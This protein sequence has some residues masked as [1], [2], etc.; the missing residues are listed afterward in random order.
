MTTY[1]MIIDAT[2]SSLTYFQADKYIY[3]SSRLGMLKDSVNV[4]G[5]AYVNTDMN[6][7]V[8][9]L[10]S[11]RYEFSN[12]LGNVLSVISDKPIP[13][14]NGGTVDYWMADIKNSQDYSPFGVML[15]GRSFG[16]TSYSYAFQAQ[17]KDD[18]IKGKGNSY[19][20][21]YRMHDTRLGRFF[22]VDPLSAKYPWNS[23]YAFSEN[24]VIDGVELEGLEWIRKITIRLGVYSESELRQATDKEIEMY[25]SQFGYEKDEKPDPDEYWR[26]VTYV[27][28]WGRETGNTYERRDKV[29]GKKLNSHFTKT[30]KQSF[31]AAGDG[32]SLEGSDD[33]ANTGN[34]A[35]GKQAPK[36]LKIVV[37]AN[38]IINIADFIISWKEG[39]DIYGKD[40]TTDKELIEKGIISGLGVIPILPPI[41]KG[42]LDG[43]GATETILND[44]D[45]IVPKGKDK[46]P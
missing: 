8:Q 35:A 40:V 45:L 37:N 27:D 23:S 42:F 14:N 10:G 4:L 33:P 29:N 19:N 13:H 44:D 41:I 31:F 5:S 6:N 3:G 30:F 20:Y 17:E 2:N 12:H 1:E 43:K 25:K 22:A 36:L 34:N 46:T 26:I 16:D 39:E 7:V 24:R 11:K 18:E 15:S 32:S 38:P 28:Y 9:T 21:T